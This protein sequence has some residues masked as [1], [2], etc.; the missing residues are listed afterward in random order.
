MPL[1]PAEI[2]KLRSMAMLC[3]TCQAEKR[4]VGCEV[5]AGCK[6]LR[7][8]VEEVHKGQPSLRDEMRGLEERLYE[9]VGV[10]IARFVEKTG[11][12][13][14]GIDFQVSEIGR[15]VNGPRKFLLDHVRCQFATR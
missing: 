12:T 8:Q 15:G 14:T 10:E 5:C 7:D 9:L 2:R 3:N 6:A 11:V 1:K 13:V 4:L